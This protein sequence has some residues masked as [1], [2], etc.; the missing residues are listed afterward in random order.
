MH[1]QPIFIAREEGA[2]AMHHIGVAPGD[3]SDGYIA[4]FHTDVDINPRWGY[5][6]NSSMMVDRPSLDGYE[7]IRQDSLEEVDVDTVTREL[8]EAA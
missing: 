3:G 1:D 5:T 7:F 4:D 8:K 6:V 2:D